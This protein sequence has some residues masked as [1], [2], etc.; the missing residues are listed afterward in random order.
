MYKA[1]VFDLDGTLLDTLDDLMDAVNAALLCFGLRQRTREEIREFVGNGAATLIRRAAGEENAEKHA[2]ILQAF[3]K[4]YGAHCADKTKPYEGVLPLLET[5]KKRGVRTAVL[6]NKPDAA[7]K[8]LADRYFPSLLCEAAGENEAA[9][10]KRKP[11]PDALFAVMERAGVKA[12]ETLYVGDSDVDVLTAKNA[13]VACIAV[14]WGFRD[15]AFL[16]EHGATAFADTP[17]DILSWL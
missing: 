12:S 9:G 16:K 13:G 4:Y 10:I 6:S 3:R 14:T 5:L 11:A 7:V 1:I 2:E 8:A 17:Q 15:R